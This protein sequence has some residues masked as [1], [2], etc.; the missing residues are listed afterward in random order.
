MTTL[1]DVER[2]GRRVFGGAHPITGGIEECLR[3]ARA[4]LHALETGDVSDLRKLVEA[5]T[6]GDA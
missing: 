4:T 1:E 2:I 5:M 6:P 3:G